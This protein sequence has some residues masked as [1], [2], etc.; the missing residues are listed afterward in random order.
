MQKKKKFIVFGSAGKGK[1]TYLNHLFLGNGPL[2]NKIFNSASGGAS[3]TTE[4][5]T[6]I[7]KIYGTEQ[8]I[9]V[10]DTPGAFT[11][12]MNLGTWL[13][14]MKTGLP[15]NFEGIFFVLS[16][17]DRT[18]PFDVLF[19][20]AFSL[21]VENFKWT[22][23][24]FVFTHCD[25]LDSDEPPPNEL[26]KI[27]VQT[28]LSTFQDQTI[29]TQI[30]LFGKVEMPNFK[31]TYREDL[32]KMLIDMPP[33]EFK[34]KKDVEPSD[35]I[36]HL[37][38]AIDPAI[39]TNRRKELENALLIQQ[40]K[41]EQKLKEVKRHNWSCMQHDKRSGRGLAG[42]H[43]ECNNHNC[44]YYDQAWLYNSI[45]DPGCTR[46]CQNCGDWMYNARDK[47]PY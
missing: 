8:E 7:H 5:K 47:C 35:L 6:V 3:C 38:Q 32:I 2:T 25:T 1:S 13:E 9:E 41:Y 33:V 14:K 24:I 19:V 26:A 34:A 23:T 10:V 28:L 42:N 17:K 20:N 16:L 37:N 40:Q 44:E 39:E 27:W 21:L 11:A 29:R 46:K 12:D 36:P 18:T 15:E 31:I 45:K 30:L 43:W 22:N 4:L